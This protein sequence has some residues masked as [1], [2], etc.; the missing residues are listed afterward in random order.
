M[1]NDTSSDERFQERRLLRDLDRG[2]RAAFDRFVATYSPAI[3]R[4]AQT[5][6]GADA[7]ADVV[8]STLLAAIE[9]LDSFR[10]DGALGAW[11]I[12]IC[13]HQVAEIRRRQGVRSRYA[14]SGDIDL[15]RVE[16]TDPSPGDDYDRRE[17]RASVH[18][19]LDLL[20]PPYGDVLEWKYLEEASVKEIAARLEVSPKAAESTLTRARAA[21]RRV[22]GAAPISW[23]IP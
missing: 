15:D 22:M 14:T 2:D 11:L 3:W 6:L 21:F 17:Q 16:T 23:R 7:A 4:Y 1:D 5:R 19:A 13:R 18:A 9:R 12:S 20:T 10:G 8:Q